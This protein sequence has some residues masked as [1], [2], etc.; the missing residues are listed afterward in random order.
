[1]RATGPAREPAPSTGATATASA[2]VRAGQAGAGASPSRDRAVTPWYRQLWPWLLIAGPAI[3]V[4][5]GLFTAWLAIVSD[6]GMIADD[7][8]K[9]GLLINRDLE[10]VRRA[11]EMK[12]G[13][14]VEVAPDGAVRVTLAG[15]DANAM[16]STVRVRFAHA[17]RAG[18]DRAATLARDP[19]GRYA[20]SV[21][22][23]PPGRWLVTV[24]T[25]AWRLPVAEV[26]G[27]LSEVRLGTARTPD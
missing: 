24:E 19:D 7:Y 17:T 4:A 14:V 2:P 9:R 15:M 16:P 1:M 10:R 8:Y 27:A 3:A 13:A 18:M 26:G 23:A 11:D 25:D 20:G 21:A 5:G 12:L 22:P 6:D